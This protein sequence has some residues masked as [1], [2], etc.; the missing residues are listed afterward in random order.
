MPFYVATATVIVNKDYCLQGAL[1]NYDESLK[2]VYNDIKNNVDV[3][4]NFDCINQTLIDEL[5]KKIYHDELVL[6]A[7][8]SNKEIYECNLKR[9]I[10]RAIKIAEIYKNKAIIMQQKGCSNGAI[11]NALDEYINTANQLKSNFNKQNFDSFI[12][13]ANE[14]KNINEN[15]DIDCLIF[16]RD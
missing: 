1:G 5:N 11:I 15:L 6:A 16:E 2:D 14:L 7:V 10:D 9:I 12:N 3:K 13:K 4:L 8:F